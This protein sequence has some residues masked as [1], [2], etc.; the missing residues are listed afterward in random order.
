MKFPPVRAYELLGMICNVTHHRIN[1]GSPGCS[2][3]GLGNIIANVA[4]GGRNFSVGERQLICLGRAMLAKPKLLFLDEATASVD[5]E[6][7]ALFPKILCSGFDDTTLLTIAHRLSTIM[8]YD[9]I[10]VVDKSKATE[11]G[12]PAKLMSIMEL[13]FSV[14]VLNQ[15]ARRAQ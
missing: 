12:M 4:E 9:V 10:L 3:R 6:T 13:D 7:D 11:F 2:S 5:G 1:F 14:N 8:D 15:L